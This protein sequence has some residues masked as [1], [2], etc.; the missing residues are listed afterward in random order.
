M[1]KRIEDMVPGNRRSI[2]E[3]P[4]ESKAQRAHNSDRT[5]PS[6]RETDIP[7]H[8][9]H[10]TPPPDR[11]KRVERPDRN[12]NRR[13]IW[14]ALAV[15]VVLVIATAAFATSS[16]LAKASFTI[17]P[18]ILPVQ[19]D[20]TIVA[21]GTSTPGYL[22]YTVIQVSG[23][24][25]TS[26]LSVD[27]P[28]V[29]TKATGKIRLYN[30]YS[31]SSQR[32]IAGTRLTDDSGLI[33]RLT[34]SVVIP[35]YKASGKDN[36]PGTITAAVIADQ[37]GTDYNVSGRDNISDFKIVA[38]KGTPKY[39]YFY[40]RLVSDITGGFAGIRK[41]VSK[42]DLASA[43]A[44]LRSD[45]ASSL[46]AKLVLEVPTGYILLSGATTSSFGPAVVGGTVS[47]KAD[48]SMESTLYGIIFKTSDLAEK[49]SGNKAVEGFSPYGYTAPGLD[50]VSLTITNPSTFSPAK[51]NSLIAKV[52]GNFDLVGTVPVNEIR[53]K[54]A[55]I[56]L[57]DTRKVLASYASV[58]DLN[59]SSGEL[60]PAWASTVPKDPSRI[61]IKINGK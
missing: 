20:S 44:K 49:L 12:H 31:A 33:Y 28:Y 61:S 21:T 37:P 56:S 6:E 57:S 2:R 30:A 1:P 46:G 53:S 8:R 15:I 11:K 34:G 58:V 26:A 3:V 47:G 27:G 59:Q 23:T 36:I 50:D 25:T 32:L 9:I 40:G 22:T 55:G 51:G 52:A 16:S 54:L 24:A 29:S 41:T 48:I 5:G 13:R 4:L 38:W 43:D 60:F 14:L 10:L 19:A 45:L 17:T 7:I 39:D 18:N 35:G 42:N